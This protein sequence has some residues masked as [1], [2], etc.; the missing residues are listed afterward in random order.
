MKLNYL[1]WPAVIAL[2]AVAIIPSAGTSTATNQ[3]PQT[4]AELTNEYRIIAKY[5]DDLVAYD[6]Q[7]VELNR[8]ARLANTDVD[9]LQTKAD[10]L[11]SRLT[12]VQSSVREIVRKLKAANEWDDLD[13]LPERFTDPGFKALFRESSFKQD[14][15]EAANGLTSHSGEISTPLDG[16]RRKLTSQHHA[17]SAVP[18]T[19]ASNAAPEPFAFVSLKC[20]L[21]VLKGKIIIKLPSV[22]PSTQLQRE[23]WAACHPGQPYPF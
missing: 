2:L 1:K 8:K 3:P 10:D 18:L 5:G 17:G 7:I 23:T 4:R 15:E 6:K 12:G 9:P 13:I 19:G 14:L 16:L 11:K 22:N 21:L 20:S